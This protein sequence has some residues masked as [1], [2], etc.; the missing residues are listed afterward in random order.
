MGLLFTL[1]TPGTSSSV[2]ISLSQIQLSKSLVT[3]H[4]HGALH[5]SACNNTARIFG[6][7]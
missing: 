4:K 6:F 7:Y 2:R 1:K 5:F 3:I